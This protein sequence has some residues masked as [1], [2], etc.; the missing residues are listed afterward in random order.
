MFIDTD[1]LLDLIK[2]GRLETIR[3]S[4]I[5]VISLLEVLRGIK[6]EKDRKIVKDALEKLLKIVGIDNEIILLYSTIYNSLKKKGKLIGDADLLIGASVISRKDVLF[7]KNKKHF[8]RLKKFG[9]ILK[10]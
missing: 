10:E 9:L 2:N 5:S 4:S 6:D 3:G 8:E 1:V 7:T